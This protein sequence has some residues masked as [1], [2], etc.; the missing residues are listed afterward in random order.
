MDNESWLQGYLTGVSLHC[1]LKNPRLSPSV[2]ASVS[3]T[4]SAA[5]F[6]WFVDLSGVAALT[7]MTAEYAGNVAVSVSYDGQTYTAPVALSDL[8]RANPAALSRETSVWFRFRLDAGADLSKVTLWGAFA[9]DI[10]HGG[11]ENAV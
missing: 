10:S 1:H 9:R 5:G 2:I 4:G 8:L 6:D 3:A 11:D 7:R